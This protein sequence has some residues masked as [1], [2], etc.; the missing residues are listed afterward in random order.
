MEGIFV[1]VLNTNKMLNPN[2]YQ[3][4]LTMSVTSYRGGGLSVVTAKNVRVSLAKT[5]M[6]KSAM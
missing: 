2:T 1:G 5:G 6:S 4:R 3:Y